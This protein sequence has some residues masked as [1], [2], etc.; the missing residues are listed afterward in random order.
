MWA[1]F[2]DLCDK[3]EGYGASLKQR[4][5]QLYGT[6]IGFAGRGEMIPNENSYCE[7]DPNTS[8]S[9]AFRYCGFIGME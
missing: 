3:E 5:R 6:H 4:C 2:D 9:G 1:M 7:I 8:I